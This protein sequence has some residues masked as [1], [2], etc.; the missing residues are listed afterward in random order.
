ME[1]A[2]TLSG[3]RLT[4][5]PPLKGKSIINTTATDTAARNAHA[6]I[7]KGGLTVRADMPTVAASSDPDKTMSA[8]KIVGSDRCATAVTL[9]WA[10]VNDAAADTIPLA[11]GSVFPCPDATR[12]T[13]FCS[14]SNVSAEGSALKF[15]SASADPSLFTTV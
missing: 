15:P 1:S 11:T 13:L 10:A 9:L 4:V 2:A 7:R 5:I 12:C 8:I 14:V 6:Y 3:P